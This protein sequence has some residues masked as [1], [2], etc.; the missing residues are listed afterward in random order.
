MPKSRKDGC[1]K[2]LPPILNIDCILRCNRKQAQF[3]E[4]K[5]RKSIHFFISR[6]VFCFSNAQISE[7]SKQSSI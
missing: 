2:S 3:A 6:S 7:S 4:R 5:E 1:R